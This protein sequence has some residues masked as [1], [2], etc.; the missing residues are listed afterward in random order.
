MPTSAGTTADT[1]MQILERQPH[2][3]SFDC[4]TPGLT[5]VERRVCRSP[6]LAE[7]DLAVNDAYAQA[8][9]EAPDQPAAVS[10][11][12]RWLGVRD[13][14]AA[15]VC[16]ERAYRRRL[17]ALRAETLVENKRFGQP[18]ESPVTASRGLTR[19]LAALAH[20]RCF[21]V[22]ERLDLGDGRAAFLGESCD[23][24]ADG[25]HFSVFHSEGHGY[26]IVLAQP[27]VSVSNLFGGVEAA[28]THGLRR[29]RTFSRSWAGGHQYDLFEYD[30][31]SYQHTMTIDQECAQV[32]AVHCWLIVR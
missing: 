23:E 24:L 4:E 9:F 18:W 16:L 26:R 3:P 1:F 6:R 30:G 29:V 13:R 19:R 20:T 17:A 15:G 28:R 11:E 32:K 8:A 10:G 7:L 14:C 12:L 5:G 21:H 31:R 27:S 22:R 2:G 25:D